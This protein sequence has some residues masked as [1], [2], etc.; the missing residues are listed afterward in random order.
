MERINRVALN[1]RKRQ[2]KG[3]IHLK[4]IPGA[5]DAAI[6]QSLALASA[7]SLNIE[8]AGENNLSILARQR[9]TFANYPSFRAY[10][11]AYGQGRLLQ[12]GQANYAIRGWRFQRNRQ[13]NYQLFL[14]IV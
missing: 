3:Y 2:F 1:L 7:V 5:S 13:G 12:R 14:E 4:I 11:P 10:Q 9:T 8:T 6:R